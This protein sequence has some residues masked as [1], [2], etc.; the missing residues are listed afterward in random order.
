[1]NTAGNRF[2]FD[3]ELLPKDSWIREDLNEYEVD[4]LVDVH[5]RRV[6]RQGALKMSFW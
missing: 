3:E 4:A 2:D 1:M 5:T 6:N